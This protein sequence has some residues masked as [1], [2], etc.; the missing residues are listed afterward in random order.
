MGTRDKLNPGIY[1][2]INKI[3][4]KKYIG[5]ATRLKER[6]RCHR[7][8]LRRN[9]HFNSHLQNAWIKYGE[10]NFEFKVIELINNYEE[11][12]LVK[13]LIE[14]E[15]FYI[16]K[17][18][19]NDRIFGYN[20]RIKCNSSLG[21]KWTKEQRERL[22]KSKLGK[23]SDLQKAS[24]RRNADKRIGKPNKQTS[25]WWK[26]LPIEEKQIIIKRKS[27][28]LKKRNKEKLKK[29]GY[30]ISPEIIKKQKE[31][32][33]KTGFIK[34][35]QA[36]NLDGSLYKLYNSYTDA[37]ND[38]SE[39]T[40]NSRKI[41]MCFKT[42]Y[43]FAYKIWKLGEEPMNKE[44]Y[45][46]IKNKA[47]SNFC[48]L[49]YKRISLSGDITFFK[50]K[51]DC[52]NSINVTKPNK[53]FNKSLINKTIYKNYYWEQIEPITGNSIYENRVKTGNIERIPSEV[54]EAEFVLKTAND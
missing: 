16:L 25:D 20:S 45:Y 40:K 47:N 17:N 26:N 50:T 6:W 2:I 42:G 7:S 18:K 31:T 54:Q 43:L 24:A 13:I 51:F 12:N 49:R 19:S 23:Y 52:V 37:L 14:K 28:T 5:S 36:Y 21:I 15:E 32:K 22:S 38:F 9:K 3:N 29:F 41:E 44:E 39:S 30:I 35:V 1:M 8:L 27:D 10:E 4:N 53:D 33:L 11:S 46:F 48:N 34:K